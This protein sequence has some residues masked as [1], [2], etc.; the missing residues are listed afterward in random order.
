[1]A[2]NSLRMVSLGRFYC[3]FF[4]LQYLVLICDVILKYLSVILMYVVPTGVR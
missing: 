4:K 2:I 1:M 3:V